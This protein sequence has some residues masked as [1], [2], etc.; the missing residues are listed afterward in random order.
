MTTP[1]GKVKK[2]IKD[3]LTKW[4]AYYFMPPAN[5]YGRAGVPDFAVCY[6]GK[7][8]AIEAKAGTKT[9]PLQ[10]REI[11]RIVEHGGAAIVVNNSNLQAIDELLK[12]V[13]D[14]DRAA[15]HRIIME[16]TPPET[17]EDE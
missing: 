17:W 8:I 11:R 15:L 4:G 1:E 3:K 10:R 2:K 9:T 5:G 12:A 13:L 7:Y 6:L 14:D 16:N